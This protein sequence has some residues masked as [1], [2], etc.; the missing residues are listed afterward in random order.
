MEGSW[1]WQLESVRG[2]RL[3]F[4]FISQDGM[5]HEVHE[6]YVDE[7]CPVRHVFDTPAELILSETSVEPR[8]PSIIRDMLQHQTYTAAIAE[9]MYFGPLLQAS[10]C[11]VDYS[12]M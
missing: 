4:C 10:R 6:A 12:S 5:L 1:P 8:L 11:I 2:R 9:G 3:M 7:A